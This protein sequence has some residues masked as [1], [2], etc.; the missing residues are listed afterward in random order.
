MDVSG[1]MRLGGPSFRPVAQANT[2]GVVFTN[3]RAEITPEAG[4]YRYEYK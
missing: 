2:L 4:M 3:V 1:G